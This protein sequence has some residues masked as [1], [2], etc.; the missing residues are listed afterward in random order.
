MTRQL[1]VVAI[2]GL[3]TTPLPAAERFIPAA[4]QE[5][6]A[7]APALPPAAEPVA[8]AKDL[9]VN[10]RTNFEQALK[11]EELPAGDSSLA[12]SGQARLSFR[13]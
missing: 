13:V 6:S 7:P 1:L 2:I 11:D 10:L 12:N 4:G 9:E 8:R 3:L 5:D